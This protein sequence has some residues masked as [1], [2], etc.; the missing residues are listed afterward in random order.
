VNQEVLEGQTAAG[1][2]TRIGIF[3]PF[4]WAHS[5]RRHSFAG[6]AA[7]NRLSAILCI[8]RAHHFFLLDEKSFPV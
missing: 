8:Y 2:D 5:M 4:F 7:V 1:Q 3:N 6:S